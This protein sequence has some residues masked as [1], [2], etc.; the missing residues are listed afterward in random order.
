MRKSGKLAIVGCALALTASLVPAAFATGNNNAWQGGNSDADK[1]SVS[2]SCVES[3]SCGHGANF[4][5]ANGDGI[6]D[7]HADGSVNGGGNGAC[8]GTG[9][10]NGTADHP[11]DGT[12][13]G[14]GATA[15]NG[16]GACD[17]TGN[18]A[19]DGNRRGAKA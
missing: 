6:C 4:I 15:G 1:S 13:N 3:D 11:S 19:A 9:N 18:A 17:G 5:D 7:T 16:N 8:D 14:Y 10:T 12:G 2:T